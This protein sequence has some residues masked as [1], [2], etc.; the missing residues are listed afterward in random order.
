[1]V[2]KGVFL[3]THIDSESLAHIWFFHGF[4]ESSL[5]FKEAFFSKLIESYSL[6]V[7]DMPGFGVSPPQ[8]K[9][10]SLEDAT[11]VI[12]SL[13]SVLSPNMAILLVGHSLGSVIATRVAQKMAEAVKGIFS[14]EGNLTR[15]DGYFSAQAAEFRQ[16]DAFHRYFLDLIYKRAPNSDVYQRYLASVR[17][18][19]P[20]AMMAWGRSSARLGELGTHG[21]DFV[22]LTCQKTYYWSVETTPEETQEFIVKYNIPN[23]QYT[24]AGHW[25]M[26]ETPDECYSAI[27][28]FFA[29]VLAESE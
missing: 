3:R 15:S 4:G 10:M 19:D 25:P 16:A 2:R 1:M 20:E 27:S 9:R 28:R 22:S 17:F 18:A 13:I 26:V 7:P 29:N 11:E 8:P 14:I 5:S 24:G 6:F 23:R 12:L 21:F